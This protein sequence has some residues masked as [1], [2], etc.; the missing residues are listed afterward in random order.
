L[1]ARIKADRIPSGKRLL[2]RYWAHVSLGGFKNDKVSPTGFHWIGRAGEA[3]HNQTG[4]RGPANDFGVY[5]CAVRNKETRADK[6]GALRSFRTP[7]PE[8]TSRTLRQTPT[9]RWE[10]TSRAD[11]KPRG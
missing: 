5:H 8:G 3:F 9:G 7:G 4:D 10:K 1:V 6:A 2:D 11:A